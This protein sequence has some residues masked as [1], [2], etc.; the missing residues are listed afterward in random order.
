MMT[1]MGYWDQPGSN[2]VARRLAALSFVLA[3]LLGVSV[4][5]AQ[6]ADEPSA[7]DEPSAPASGGSEQATGQPITRSAEQF[8]A[9]KGTRGSS[10]F[11]AAVAKGDAAFL[12]QD[13][14]AAMSEYQA[15]LKIEPQNAVGHLRLGEALRAQDKIKEAGEAFTTALR[16]AH[17]AQLKAKCHFLRADLRERAKLWDGAIEKWDAY[18]E[19]AAGVKPQDEARVFPNVAE[20]RKKRIATVKQM[21]V[22]YA[23]V[24]ER[25]KQREQE[26][27][28]ETKK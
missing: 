16:F 21:A 13:Y 23:A 24:A 3:S 2:P 4:A 26:G 1:V 5:S 15:A 19:F 10:T 18:A 27:S 8:V 22:Q 12:A 17:T 14:P 20:E 28:D 7:V 6:E 25:I 11:W 9:P